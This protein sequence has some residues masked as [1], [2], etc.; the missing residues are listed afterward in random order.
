[1][2]FY[3]SVII[4][5]VNVRLRPPFT[6]RSSYCLS[7]Y[8]FDPLLLFGHHIV[9]QCTASTPLLLFGHHTV[10]QC[11]ASTPLLLFGHHIVCQCTAST[12]LLLFGHHIVCQCTASTPLWYLQPFFMN[13]IRKKY[14]VMLYIGLTQMCYSLSPLINNQ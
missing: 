7:M 12:P 3:F 13:K 6:F 14:K 8:G 4:L 11:T 1:M 2:S 10:C 9:C 5:S